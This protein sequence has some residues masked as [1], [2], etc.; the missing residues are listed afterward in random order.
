MSVDTV[1]SIIFFEQNRAFWHFEK[2]SFFYQNCR[3]CRHSLQAA[4]LPVVCLPPLKQRACGAP[5]IRYTQQRRT[6][7]LDILSNKR[8]GFYSNDCC[9]VSLH[10]IQCGSSKWIFSPNSLIPGSKFALAFFPKCL[11][12]Q[13]CFFSWNLSPQ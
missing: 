3:Y 12:H 11:C 5:S 13:A 1:P 9:Q 2:K 7:A 8:H 10:V 4:P 6:W